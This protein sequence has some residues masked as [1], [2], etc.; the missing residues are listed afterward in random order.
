[1]N[2]ELYLYLQPLSK[3]G[4]RRRTI[5]K[6]RQSPHQILNTNR[7]ESPTGSSDGSPGWLRRRISGLGTASQAALSG[8]SVKQ[9]HPGILIPNRGIPLP[10]AFG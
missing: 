3:G 7:D 10:R 9:S 2:W 5:S 1:M 8:I 6:Q 4:P